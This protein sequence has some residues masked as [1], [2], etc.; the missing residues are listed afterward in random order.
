MKFVLIISVPQFPI[1]KTVVVGISFSEGCCANRFVKCPGIKVM[2]L[3][4]SL[5]R[6]M[7]RLDLHLNTYYTRNYLVMLG[8]TLIQMLLQ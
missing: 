1:W 3:W 2:Q 6:E 7:S 8:S 5:G 4:S